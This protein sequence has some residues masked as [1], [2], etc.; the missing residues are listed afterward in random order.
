M[1]RLLLPLTL[2][3]AA[4]PTPANSL[5]LF[6]L[7]LFGEC[8]E[9]PVD[10]EII[11]P[12][13]FEADLT[14]NGAEDLDGVRA[15]VQNSSRLLTDDDEPAPGSSGLI[16]IARGDYRRILAGLYN[17]GH[18]APV[19][20]I[21]VNGQEASTLQ[22]GADLPQGTR[23]EVVVDP[24]P[25]FVF[26]RAEIID[27]APRPLDRRDEVALPEDEGFVS[28]SPAPAGTVRR[29]GSLAVDAWRQQGHPK[30]RIER[31]E[32]VAD[33]PT[34]TLDATL[35]VDPGPRAV[36]GPVTVSGT[37]RM[38]P[39]F[40]ATQTG[41]QPGEEY[42]PDD[43]DRARDRLARLRVF[44]TIRLIEAEEVGPNGILPIE[45]VV[46]EQ[47]LRRFGIGGTV[48]NIDGLGAETFFIHRNLFGRAERLRLD[49]AIGGI[50]TDG[51]GVEDFDYELGASLILP[52]RIT[53]DTDIT[54]DLRGQREV[55]EAY[56]ETSIDGAIGLNHIFTPELTGRLALAASRSRFEDDLGTRDFTTL[57][58]VG[59]LNFDSRDNELDATE[60]FY[61]DLQVEPFYEFEFGTTAVRT[62]AEGRAYLG[63]GEDDTFVLAGRAKIGST[64]GGD[65]ERTA[66]DRLFFAG[67][68]GSVR[69]YAY[70]NIGII[71][72]DGDVT[73]GLSLLE[74]SLELRA[75]NIFGN[76]GAAAFVDAGVVSEETFADFGDVR[77]GV[78]AGIRYDTGLGP[79]RLDL[80]VPL[81]SRP[82]DPSVGIYVGLGQA[83]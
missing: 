56:T 77:V 67:G 12:L 5:E 60:G 2:S 78:G 71:Q 45:V 75:R 52:G 31:R 55:L 38:I 27:R 68:G 24:G 50:G 54:F 21:L 33:H 46:D 48:S 32:I 22:V 6:G 72:P 20:S 81:D 9:E 83:F 63:F 49:A 79:L 19:I 3:L 62:A 39:S 70:R 82:G 26:G 44:R 30:A 4:M 41:L 7:C 28:G 69:G 37:R 1:R 34:N 73:G 11:D 65:V 14:F 13:T 80:A 64:F 23:V 17:Q 42:D 57:G 66:P 16:A 25:A 47:K 29:A 51:F 35:D 53:P 74:T 43:I 40:V 76:F 18:Y 36:Y 61:A 58:I 8:R 59:G 15:A 10:P